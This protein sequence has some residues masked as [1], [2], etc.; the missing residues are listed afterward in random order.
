MSSDIADSSAPVKI[1]PRGKTIV[2][3]RQKALKDSTF[4]SLILNGG[5]LTADLLKS[6]GQLFSV[7]GLNQCPEELALLRES[8]LSTYHQHRDIVEQYNRFSA[9][10]EWALKGFSEELTGLSSEELIRKQY[11]QLV[12][13]SVENA[14]EVERTWS[15]YELRRRCHF[16]F[17]MLLSA[18]TDTLMDLSEGTPEQVLSLW[19]TEWNYPNILVG[20]LTEDQS[21]FDK[22]LPAIMQGLPPDAFLDGSINKRAA[23]DL[24]PAPRAVYALLILVACRMQ[25]DKARTSHILPDRSH[26]L[27]RAFAILADQTVP[28]PMC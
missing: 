6:E 15:E 10:V 5:I 18:L 8:F 13:S 2:E 23:R 28:S 24:S 11:I 26:Y 16:A 21:P 14:A 19:R 17:E 22:K 7:N 3:A 1:S 20:L 27:E 12:T 25:T 4:T 9:T